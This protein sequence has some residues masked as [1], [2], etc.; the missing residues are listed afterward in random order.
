[1][2]IAESLAPK[3]PVE[4]MNDTGMKSP[5]NMV[6]TGKVWEEV[7]KPANPKETGVASDHWLPHGTGSELENSVTQVS[8]SSH[9]HPRHNV[10]TQ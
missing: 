2:S 5:C 6:R 7:P 8:V 3:M 4:K 1:M 10:G 9:Y